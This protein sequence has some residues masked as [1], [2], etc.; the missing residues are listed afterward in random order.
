MTH[1]SRNTTT[2]LDFEAQVVVAKKDGIDLSK[3]KLLEQFYRRN[4][5]FMVIIDRYF[6]LLIYYRY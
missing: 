5:F 6:F 4:S 1:A 2:G 3:R